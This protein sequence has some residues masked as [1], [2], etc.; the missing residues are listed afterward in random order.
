MLK[1]IL[2]IIVVITTVMIAINL[3]S[4][5]TEQYENT[6][7]SDRL[8]KTYRKDGIHRKIVYNRSF[9]ALRKKPLIKIF[10]QDKLFQNTILYET[11]YEKHI[12][13][14]KIC[15]EK[16]NGVCVP[17]GLS[18]YATCFPKGE[19]MISHYEDLKDDAY[20]TENVDER[21]HELNFA[22]LR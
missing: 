18:G 11:D 20:G 12:S 10:A 8:P 2:I 7:M 19:P 16:C 17:Y 22:N 9:D 21:G 6:P 13:G 5:K 15:R 4:T 1:Y 3:L 14:E